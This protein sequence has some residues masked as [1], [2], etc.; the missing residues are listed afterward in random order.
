M[1]QWV[2]WWV[3]GFRVRSHIGGI[4][5]S[6]VSSNLW[7]LANKG[8]ESQN[9]RGKFHLSTI[10]RGWKAMLS[11]QLFWMQ[12]PNELTDLLSPNLWP[13]LKQKSSRHHHRPSRLESNWVGGQV[14]CF[15]ALVASNS[16]MLIGKG[17]NW[18]PQLPVENK[19]VVDQ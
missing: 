3:L 10:P 1:G 18:A 15:D 4:H 2:H 17:H 13:F 9:T 7:K 5:E 16:R 14:T 6:L 19:R 12:W 11:S 8:G